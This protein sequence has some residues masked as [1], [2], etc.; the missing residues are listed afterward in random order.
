MSVQG[1]KSLG[2]SRTLVSD[3]SEE[4][5]SEWLCDEG[6]EALVDTFR[7]HNIDGAE[8]ISLNTETL[9]TEF[10]IESVGLRGRVLRKIK[11][12]RSSLMDSDVPDE[13][14]CS[15]TRELMKDPIIAADGFSYERE[16]MESWINTPNRSSPMTNLPLQTTLLTANRSLKMAIQRWKSS[17]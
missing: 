10:N 8:L 7:A 3:W 11:D 17:H 4:D 2:Y 14:L 13:F 15:I 9:T 1:R 16:A 5:V 6:L 12:L